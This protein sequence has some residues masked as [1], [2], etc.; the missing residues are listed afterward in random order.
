MAAMTAQAWRNE[1]A[2]FLASRVQTGG[3]DLAHINGLVCI[4]FLYDNSALLRRAPLMLHAYIRQSLHPR[5]NSAKI[6]IRPLI[7]PNAQ[8][9]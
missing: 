8:P 4:Q 3:F 5:L 6:P 1:T 2:W 9:L 7:I